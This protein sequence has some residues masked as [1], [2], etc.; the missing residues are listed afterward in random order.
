MRRSFRIIKRILIGDRGTQLSPQERLDKFHK[1]VSS[2]SD[3]PIKEAEQKLGVKNY[4]DISEH[5]GYL[6][7]LIY[8]KV[9]SRK[10]KLSH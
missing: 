5:S 7:P 6:S 9:K 2:V 1:L 8:K 4:T 10:S 3:L